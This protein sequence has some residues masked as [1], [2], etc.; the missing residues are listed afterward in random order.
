MLKTLPYGALRT[1]EA[2]VRLRGFSRAAEELNV[3]QSAVSQHVRQLEDW[4]GTQLFVRRGRAVHPTEAAERLAG[5]TRESFGVLADLCD[6]LRAA[7]RSVPKGVLVASPPGFAF[8]WLLPRL[9]HFAELCPDHPV[10]LSTDPLSLDPASTEADV[11]ISYGPGP[12]GRSSESALMGEHLTPACAPAIATSLTNVTDLAQHVILLDRMEDNTAGTSW[13]TWADGA[14]L[15]LPQF[16]QS[17]TLG[18]ANL[19]VQAAIDGH[20]VAMGRTPLVQDALDAG[21]LV[22]P[23]PQ[24]VLSPNSYW[25]SLPQSTSPKEQVRLFAEW[26]RSE[27]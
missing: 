21:T 13:Q 3:T 4:L 15:T 6:D 17:R 25:L 27:A 19:V 14:G 23:F 22:Q 8:L 20:G 7:H 24:S 12:P 18:Q 2:V 11:V 1:L 16:G 10:S 5:T 26:L 9:L